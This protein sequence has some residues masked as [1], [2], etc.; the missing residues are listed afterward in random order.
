MKDT[1][2][3]MGETLFRKKSLERISSPEALNDY[4]HVT[5]PSVWLILLAVILLLAGML[6]WSSA[7]SID[8]FAT[9]TAQ[10]TDG[11]MY[12][13]FDN[14][15]I[16]ENVQS[17]MTV[18]AGETASRISSIGKD[19]EGELFALA[20]TSLADGTYPVRIVFKQTQVLSLLF[21]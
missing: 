11:T 16:A 18:T 15:Q 14:E 9:G 20:P 8:S 1:S 2:T 4:L 3:D 7:A 12:I 5:S 21:N 10:V 6:V 17:G 19:A 13:H